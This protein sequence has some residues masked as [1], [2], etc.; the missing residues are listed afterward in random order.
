LRHEDPEH[1]VPLPIRDFATVS[2]PL[3]LAEPSD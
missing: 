1:I 3:Q 2:V